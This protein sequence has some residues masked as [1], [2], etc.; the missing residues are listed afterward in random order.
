MDTRNI[1]NINFIYLSG[2]NTFHQFQVGWAGQSG[3]INSPPSA[4]EPLKLSPLRNQPHISFKFLLPSPI[5]PDC[6]DIMSSGFVSSG[7]NEQPVERDDDW[8]RAEQELEEERRRKA[9]IGKQNDGKSL[10]EV[11]EQNKSE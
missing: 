7:T 9:E 10:F 11:L 1:S 6:Q 5:V 8:L 2:L 4:S 3:W